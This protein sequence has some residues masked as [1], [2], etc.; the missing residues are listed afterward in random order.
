MAQ[1][2]GVLGVGDWG[3]GCWRIDEFP[4]TRSAQTYVGTLGAAV[5]QS[6][7]ER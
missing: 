7:I 2:Q 5:T 3:V 1:G 4:N 6:S